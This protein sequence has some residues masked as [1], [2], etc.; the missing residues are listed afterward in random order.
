M[1]I[2]PEPVSRETQLIILGDLRQYIREKKHLDTVRTLLIEL[3]ERDEFLHKL[4]DDID[5]LLEKIDNG[6]NWWQRIVS[7]VKRG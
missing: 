5:E 1:L 3:K 4:A 2:N 6:G 7:V